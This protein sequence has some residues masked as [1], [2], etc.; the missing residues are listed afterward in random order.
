MHSDG[1]VGQRTYMPG[2][3]V[4]T[5]L[6]V[7]LDLVLTTLIRITMSFAIDNYFRSYR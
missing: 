1:T 5:A 7:V 2:A 3:C 6:A 4:Q